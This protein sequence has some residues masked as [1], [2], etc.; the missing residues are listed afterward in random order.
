MQGAWLD[1]AHLRYSSHSLP[2]SMRCEWMSWRPTSCQCHSRQSQEILRVAI[3]HS[4]ETSMLGSCKSSPF[5]GDNLGVIGLPGIWSDMIWWGYSESIELSMNPLSI[6]T[7]YC[8]YCS[9]LCPSDTLWPNYSSF[10][11]GT[12]KK[13][14]AAPETSSK[15]R[16]RYPKQVWS[17]WSSS[18]TCTI[19][20]LE[21]KELGTPRQELVWFSYVDIKKLAPWCALP[22]LSSAG[23]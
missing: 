12:S 7:L 9:T 18:A 5:I 19:P 13:Q 6:T 22:F 4:D 10:Q 1:R 17:I 8:W 15:A 21:L 20:V 3:A 23:I 2:G 16:R 14:R 11:T